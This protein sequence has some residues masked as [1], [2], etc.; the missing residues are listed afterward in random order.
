MPLSPGTI[1]GP[2]SVTAKI[3]EGGMGEVYRARDT[4]LD[5]DVALKVLPAAFTSDP[6]R[7][8]RFEREAKVLASL[9]HTNIGHIYG[10]EEADGQKALVL[11][12]VEG[13]TLAD[14][15]AAG[16]IPVDEALPIAKQIA[17]A[18][19]VAHEAG[20]IHRD[21]KPA[22]IKVREDGTVKVLDFGLAKAVLGESSGSDLS[23]SPTVTIV[24][25]A[26]GVILGT[27]TYM[28][29]EQARGKPLDRRTDIWSFGCVLYET[30]T[31]QVA[32]RGDTLSDTV[33]QILDREPDWHALPSNTPPLII[34]LLR[35]CLDKNPRDR[36][37]HIGDARVE[38]REALSTPAGEVPGAVAVSTPPALLRRVLP[39]A[40]AGIAIAGLIASLFV[41]SS[42][43]LTT[44][45][46][47]RSE[48]PMGVDRFAVYGFDNPLSHLVAISSDGTRVAFAAD[49]TIWQR[50]FDRSQASP[51]PG[52]ESLEGQAN[53]TRNP[54]FSPD[55]EWIGF[56]TFGQGLHKVPVAGGPVVNLCEEPCL[57][58][59]WGATWGSD[60][61]ILLG[62]GA[63]G[64]WQVSGTGGTP[65]VLISVGD[66]EEAQ[67]PQKLP[68]GEWVL[69]SLR[70]AGSSW[71]DATV[72]A[73]SVTTGQRTTLLRGGHD[74]R[75]VETGH[76][77]YARE[78]ALLAVPF[79]LETLTV[80]GDPVSLIEGIWDLAA[81][82]TGVAQFSVSHNGSLV[83]LAEDAV[84]ELRPVVTVD[85]DGNMET[86]AVKP[87]RHYVP[88]YSPNGERLAIDTSIDGNR[89]IL[90][91]DL[92][93]GV[94]SQ[95][96]SGADQDSLPVWHPDGIRLAFRSYQ[97]REAR[98]I[99]VRT[100]DGTGEVT[101]LTETPGD[102][103]SISPD[104]RW[105]LFTDEGD[106]AIVAVD[107][108]GEPRSIVQTESVYTKDMAF[109]PRGRFFAYD[110]D[111]SDQGEVYVRPFPDVDDYRVKVS[112]DGGLHPVWAPN[113]Q[114]L[115]Y[116]HPGSGKIMRVPYDT[117]PVFTP[118]AP[119]A[120][121]DGPSTVQTTRGY[122][123]HPDGDKFVMIEPIGDSPPQLTLIQNF[124][125]LLKERV[126]VP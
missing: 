32:F 72:V 19:E 33:V 42:T 98:S 15:I 90:I 41:G 59:P 74:A 9:N 21:L 63:A 22:N 61:I 111:E 77:V 65:E 8:A 91:H 62:Q 79:D 34:R 114:E 92:R 49:G 87:G 46:V 66:G 35:R 31:G 109:S 94:T 96:A 28:S 110:S 76:L 13:P 52:L 100:A 25:T 5:R 43:P 95:L 7:L 123:I 81:D 83:Y 105:L 108:S 30:L 97:G 120:L 112:R 24:G 60:D 118:G 104:G 84:A 73:V 54:F 51:V 10:L 124:F 89:A 11:E 103:Y 69:F 93:S 64:I 80:F 67:G 50:P 82:R 4:K 23:R 26:T 119:V 12:L 37:Q 68:G 18:L 36:L 101:P 86:L 16:P 106:V 70:T 125:E 2:Y 3:G 116:Y 122:D 27:A 47:V 6:D 55:G 38:L 48:I 45:Q 40:V 44:S 53:R 115:Y 71:N 78:G 1:L 14:R 88:R 99:Y 39:W 102:P 126:P 107:G 29:P 117:E 57:E 85:F 17:E 56:Y 75:Y 113:R 20:V 58:R 121:V